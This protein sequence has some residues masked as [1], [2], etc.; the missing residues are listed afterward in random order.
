[1]DETTFLGHHRQG[2]G[3]LLGIEIVSATKDRVVGEVAVGPRQFTRDGVVHGGLI[4]ALADATSACGAVLNLPPDCTTATIESKT[5]FLRRG[6]GDL[7]R[8]VSVPLHVGRTTSVWR[9]TVARGNGAPIAE[10]TQTQI[11]LPEARAGASAAENDA[12]AGPE[13]SKPVRRRARAEVAEERKRQIFEGA[14]RVI[15]RKGFANAS[16]REIAA[17]AGMPVPTMYEYIRRKE[18]LLYLIYESFMEGYREELES[19]AAEPAPSTTKIERAIAETVRS[20]DENHR[21]IKLMF[22][23]TRSLDASARRKVYELDARYIG[24]WR[25][26]LAAL[27]D[28]RG[29]SRGQIELWANLIYFL[30]TVWPLRYWSIGGHGRNAVTDSITAFVMR[31]LDLAPGRGE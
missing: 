20:F 27:A 2:L 13:P 30:C 4:M 1:M 6:E 23:E 8:S 15:A 19:I 24:V 9:A 26:L 22:Q 7:V 14:C 25:E 10:V 16:M 11:V 3:G 31:G 28:E 29:A 12:P 5:N 18:D 17:A 21:Y